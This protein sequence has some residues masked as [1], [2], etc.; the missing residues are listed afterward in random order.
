MEKIIKVNYVNQVYDQLNQ[1]ILDKVISEGNK[2]PSEMTLAREMNVSRPVVRE[3]LQRLRAEHK[4][5]T[6]Q[7][8]G[9]F[10]ANPL[11]YENET[12]EGGEDITEREFQE[13][14]QFRAALEYSAVV[15]A[16]EQRTEEDLALIRS[17]LSAM[18][19]DPPADVYSQE[20]EA[21]HYSV[22]LATH[23]PMVIKAYTAVR[24]EV[25]RVLNYLN[26]H[27]GAHGI[28]GNF[29]TRLYECIRDRTPED[30]IRL[31]KAHDE[32]NYARVAEYQKLK[33]E[34]A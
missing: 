15:Q 21:F 6:H 2:L 8:M 16:A 9:S 26:R 14:Q 25:F 22:Y 29:H 13:F 5:I 19:Q 33:G 4:I 17:H 30:A 28:S 34:K 20:D 27:K 18:L 12:G 32:Y 1:M 3:A 23:N 10:C 31:M 7:G 24:V 11:N